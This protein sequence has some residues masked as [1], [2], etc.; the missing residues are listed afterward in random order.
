MREIAIVMKNMI[1]LSKIAPQP[2]GRATASDW[3]RLRQ[4]NIYA[5]SG[6]ADRTER[7]QYYNEE[8]PYLLRHT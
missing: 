7:E 2:S 6:T 4:I 1:Q 8:L 3:G 5:P